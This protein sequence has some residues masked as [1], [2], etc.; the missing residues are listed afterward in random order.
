MIMHFGLYVL[1]IWCMIECCNRWTTK[2]TVAWIITIINTIIVT[3][4]GLIVLVNYIFGFT[5]YQL[6]L[7]SIRIFTVNLVLDSV[8]GYMYYPKEF[9]TF[10]MVHHIVYVLFTTVCIIPGDREGVVIFSMFLVEEFPI[11]LLSF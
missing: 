11:I 2:S 7:T 1:S 5:N 8:L 6:A 10:G 4:L 3:V 9:T